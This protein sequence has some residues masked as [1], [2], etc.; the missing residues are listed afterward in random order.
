M[1]F[2]LK[3]A[4]INF[5]KKWQKILRGSAVTYMS[6]K[7]IYRKVKLFLNIRSKLRSGNDFHFHFLD[8]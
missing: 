2:A 7:I 5:S 3:L 4:K 1:E 8:Y 6:P